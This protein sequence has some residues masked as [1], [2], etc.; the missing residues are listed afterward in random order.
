MRTQTWNHSAFATLTLGFTNI[1]PYAS[2]AQKGT[3][4]QSSTQ[5]SIRSDAMTDQGKEG[6]WSRSQTLDF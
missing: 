5:F 6:G 4:E 1:I 3:L 2:I